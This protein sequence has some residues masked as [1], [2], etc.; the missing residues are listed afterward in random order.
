MQRTTRAAGGTASWLTIPAS[1]LMH[2]SVCPRASERKLAGIFFRG[3]GL[4]G[5]PPLLLVAQAS[6][7]HP[8]PA[9]ATTAR[10]V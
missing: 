6:R 8:R 10:M 2:S 5:G 3:N 9:R 4:R 7:P 1:T